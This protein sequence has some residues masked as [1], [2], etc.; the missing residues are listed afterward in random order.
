M[1]QKHICHGMRERGDHK[2]QFAICND[3]RVATWQFLPSPTRTH[4][5][6]VFF[7][8]HL[9][10]YM[11]DRRPYQILMMLTHVTSLSRRVVI[12]VRLV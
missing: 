2:L 10:D 1:L 7:S 12:N 3:K 4:V 11:S 9:G 5:H 8:H 6:V